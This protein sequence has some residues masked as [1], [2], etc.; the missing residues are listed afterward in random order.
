[1]SLNRIKILGVPF[2]NV[3]Q[4]EALDLVLEAVKENKKFFVVTPNPEICLAA[5]KDAEFLSALES[6]QLSIPDGFGILWAARYLHG[7]KTIWRFLGTLVSPWLSKKYSPLKE[8][9]T[10]TD[11]MQVFCRE[12]PRKKIFLLGASKEVN[13]KLSRKL[14]DSGVNIVGNFSGDASNKLSSIICSM[15]NSSEAEVLFVAFGAPKQ[16]KWI[17]ENFR[18]LRTVKVA[19]GVGGAFDFLA[20]SRRRAPDWMR[21][22]GLEWLYRLII[23][24][25]RIKRICNAVVVFPW[26]VFRSAT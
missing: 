1:M 14:I 20:G 5:A 3:T 2:N 25:K 6:A 10:G 12:H 24:P 11:L 21:K 17:R 7:K 9:V 23:E 15:I 4:K 19:I 26:K 16:E 13:E 18:H 8:R 22:T